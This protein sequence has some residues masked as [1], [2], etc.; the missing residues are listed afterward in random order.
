[1]TK[2]GIDKEAKKLLSKVLCKLSDEEEVSKLLKSL[3]SSSELKDLSRRLLAAK[4][5]REKLTYQ[6]I[7]DQ[8]GMSSATVNKIY[9]K[10]RGCPVLKKLF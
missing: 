3:M 7:E 9:F 10:T 6:N 2:K 8:M 1:M 4:L 5:L